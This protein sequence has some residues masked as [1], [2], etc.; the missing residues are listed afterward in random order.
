MPKSLNQVNSKRTICEVH[1]EMYDII[2]DS[3]E[4]GPTKDNLESKIEEAFLMAKKMDGKLRQYKNNYDDG[5][6]ER[7]SEAIRSQKHALR[8]MRK[9]TGS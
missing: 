7:E 8:N 9:G 5:W 3:L 4:P 2:I 6:W 1:R